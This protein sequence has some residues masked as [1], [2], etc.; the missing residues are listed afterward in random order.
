MK[1]KLI[2]TSFIITALS[3][4]LACATWAAGQ[5]IDPP[6]ESGTDVVNGGDTSL[7]DGTAMQEQVTVDASAQAAVTMAADP[8][9]P[10]GSG[11]VVDPYQIATKSHLEMM[12]TASNAFYVLVADIDLNNE[13][14]TPIGSSTQPFTGR[15]DGNGYT[16]SNLKVSQLKG[17]NI[18][19]FWLY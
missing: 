10:S 7:A 12:R 13:E 14:W 9:V 8:N 11:T 4:L 1:R 17:T 6:V 18:G 2:T 3:L 5:A 15:F 16:I 19:F